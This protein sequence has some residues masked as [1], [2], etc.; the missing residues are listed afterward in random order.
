M[1]ASELVD[2]HKLRMYLITSEQKVYFINF[3]FLVI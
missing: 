1:L 2:T 3:L